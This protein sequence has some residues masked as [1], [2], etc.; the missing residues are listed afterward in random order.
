MTLAV[1]SDKSLTNKLL[2]TSIY[3]MKLHFYIVALWFLG[4]VFQHFTRLEAK[5]SLFSLESLES[6]KP[7][8]QW[9]S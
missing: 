6:P 2:I 1:Q 9:Y 8:G 4:I 3:D 5:G 7:T